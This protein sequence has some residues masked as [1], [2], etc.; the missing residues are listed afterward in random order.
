MYYVYVLESLKNGNL[1]FGFTYNIKF[2]LERHNSGKVVS[3]KS[4]IPWKVI[5]FEGYVCKS[6]ALRREKYFK[7]QK[8]KTTIKYMLKD[9]LNN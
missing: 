2:R 6:D 9:Y 8:G 4:Y 5:F 7:T 3:T 1:Y